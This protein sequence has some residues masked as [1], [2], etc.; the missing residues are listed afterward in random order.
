MW[1]CRKFPVGRSAVAGL[2][3]QTVNIK[4]SLPIAASH[5]RRMTER[6]RDG[7]Q[8]AM[9]FLRSVYGIPGIYELLLAQRF[10]EG[11]TFKR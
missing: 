6:R 5:R 8:S 9:S 3:R 7:P 1:V 4:H 10:W 11:T 2:Y